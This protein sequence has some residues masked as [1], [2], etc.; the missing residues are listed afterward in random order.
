MWDLKA[1][2]IQALH[3]AAIAL[4]GGARKGVVLA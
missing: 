4:I 1:T 2:D 3:L